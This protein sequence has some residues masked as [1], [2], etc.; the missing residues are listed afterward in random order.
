V[1]AAVSAAAG[2]NP[3]REFFLLARLGS[4]DLPGA[5][6]VT[7]LNF[8]PS[9]HPERSA[10]TE[11]LYEGEENPLLK[12]SLAGVQLKFSMRLD[13]QKGLTIPA[14][15]SVGDWIVKLPDERPGFDAVPEPE[16]AG[17][18]LAR[19]SGVRV[20]ET[21]LVAVKDIRGLPNWAY[22]RPGKALAVSRFDR[23]PGDR[24]VHAEELAQVMDIPTA[25]DTAKYTRA[26]FE[27]VASIIAALCGHEALGEV[28]DRIVLN[29]LIGNGDGH[30]KNWAVTY[31]NGILPQLS[32]A[33]DILPT[34][35]YIRNDNLG[36][37]LN[38]SRDFTD[39][40]LSSFARMAARVGVEAE[41]AEYS[42]RRMV[43]KVIDC[44]GILREL[45]TVEKFAALTRHRD[46]L[47]LIRQV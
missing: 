29:V 31:P 13:A 42:A 2:I 38:R 12:F 33:Y 26:N 41:W 17:L 8:A 20:P 22:L 4:D 36:L 35:L 21:M 27:T 24:R 3:K 9:G 5:I 46:R 6:R 11:D 16:F 43:E 32:P 23:A 28:I 25:I 14:R 1:R 7:A 47:P 19:A 39:V 44:W 30:L 34:V 45:L 37:K 40:T 18:E 10:P 15:G